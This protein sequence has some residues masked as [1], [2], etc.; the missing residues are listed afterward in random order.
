MQMPQTWIWQQPD[1][2]HFCWR[3][4]ELSAALATARLAQ[5]K[6]LGAIDMLSAG[7][8]EEALAAIL[9]EDGVTTSAIEGESLDV[10]A[11]RSSVARHLGLPFAGF[12]KSTRSVDGLIEVLLDATVGY[13]KPLTQ[14]RLF[15]WQAALFPTGRLRGERP[16]QVVSGR[17]GRERVHFVAPSR[18]ALPAEM[19]AFL[20]WFDHP[21]ADVDGLIHAGLAHLWFITLHPFEDGN[22][23]LARAITD[24]AISRD[25]KK[26]MRLFSLSAQILLEREA[27]YKILES[28]QRG[29][30][31]VTAWLI[32]FLKQVQAA[33]SNAD[34]TLKS[35]LAKA[36]FWS[37]HQ[38]ANLNDRQR[39]VLN[40]LLDA[41]SG[42]FEGGMNTRKY[43]SLAKT[44]RASAYRE[45]NDLV[46]KGCLKTTAQGGRSSGYEIVW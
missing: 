12:S 28:T 40:R 46:E 5:G 39:K 34:Q 4:G 18:S 13:D 14:A 7:L 45:L 3:D 11:V 16:M 1:W 21:Q 44:S 26:P 17:Q 33:A 35:T 30:L 9:I 36:R 29:G 6:V 22:G 27:Y 38:N 32:W 8:S 23:R 24:M 43:V 25:E 20:R 41:G 10:E 19:K 15:G 2:P 31:D 37:R 42:R